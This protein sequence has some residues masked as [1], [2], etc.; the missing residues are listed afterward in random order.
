MQSPRPMDRI[1][2]GDVGFGKTEV[3]MRAAFIA[4]NSGK[5]VAMLV[6]TNFTRTANLSKFPG[7]LCRLAG[8]NCQPDSI[9]P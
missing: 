9:Y 8:A 6:P 1:V 3:S 4:A 2:C 5:Q 7:S